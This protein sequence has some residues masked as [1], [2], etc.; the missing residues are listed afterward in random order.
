MA[1]KLAFLKKK[2]ASRAESRRAISANAALE[3]FDAPSQIEGGE[4]R[5]ATAAMSYEGAETLA[6]IDWVK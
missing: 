3:S 4:G 2:T 6:D 5:A 1:E